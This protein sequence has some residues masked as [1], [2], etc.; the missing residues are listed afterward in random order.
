M[1]QISLQLRGGLCPGGLSC[2]NVRG[3]CFHLIDIERVK[4]M[5]DFQ[6]AKVMK[7]REVDSIKFEDTIQPILITGETIVACF[8]SVRDY[9]VFTS[10]RMITVNVQGLTG[11]KCDYTSL[12]YSKIQTFS[13]ETAGWFELDSELELWFSGLGKVRLEFLGSKRIKD[14]CR[15]IG[16]VVL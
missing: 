14:I 10:K 13:I 9:V 3:L 2:Y 1:R 15:L 12:P 16:E 6:N 11:K 5:I 4:R 8:Q 7:L